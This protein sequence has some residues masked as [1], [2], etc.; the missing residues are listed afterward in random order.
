[1]SGVRPGSKFRKYRPCLVLRL[2]RRIGAPTVAQFT[3]V[4]IAELERWAKRGRLPRQHQA[5]FEALRDRLDEGWRPWA[6]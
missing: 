3:G 6:A 4:S 2:V 1:M 5:S